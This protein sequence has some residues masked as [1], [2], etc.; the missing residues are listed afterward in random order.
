MIKSFLLVNLFNL[1]CLNACLADIE[2]DFLRSNYQKAITDNNLCRNMIDEL[3]GSNPSSIKLAYLGALQTIWA[4]HVFNP[5]SK[6]ST[7]RKGKSNIEKAV[8]N[9]NGNIEIRFIRLSV[10]MNCPKFLQ[11]RKNIEADILF[12]KNHVDKI[13]PGDLRKM[14]T[15]ILMK[16]KSNIGYIESNS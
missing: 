3:E 15:D 10:Q 12:L 8:E 2:L 13:E 11:Y 5:F 14:I 9:E 6:L 4:N 16:R 1:L 7:F